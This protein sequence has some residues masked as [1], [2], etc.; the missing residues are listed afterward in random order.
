MSEELPQAITWADPEER[1]SI[2]VKV[3]EIKQI[4]ANAPERLQRE[5]EKNGSPW[6]EAFTSDVTIIGGFF[7]ML[8][9]T[10]PE[11]EEEYKFADEN[12]QQLLAELETARRTYK[13][14]TPEEV[15]TSLMAHLDIF[16]E[17]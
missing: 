3:G 2:E 4:I 7:Q 5:L 1:K 9:I 16:K 12:L 17:N 8:Q 15:K 11:A 14:D 10:F 13:R 6:I